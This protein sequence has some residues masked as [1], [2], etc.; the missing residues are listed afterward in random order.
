[1]TE[2]YLITPISNGPLSFT[3]T[4]IIYYLNCWA[5]YLLFGGRYPALLPVGDEEELIFRENTLLWGSP[6]PL[7]SH[8]AL[9][10]I[11]RNQNV[12]SAKK[13]LSASESRGLEPGLRGRA[14]PQIPHRKK[15]SVAEIST[16]IT[17][18]S[19]NSLNN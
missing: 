4:Y 6:S 10:G 3:R 11:S 5:M 1:M 14:S 8:P 2:V 12:V 9:V 16:A 19:T 13:C 17:T 18:K 15:L 7:M